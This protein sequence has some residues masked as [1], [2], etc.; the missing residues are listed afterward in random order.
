MN[1]LVVNCGS[2]TIKY[3]LFSMEEEDSYQVLAKG[4]VERIGTPGSC[5]EHKNDNH[6][7]V[8][9]REVSNHRVAM[10]WVMEV[11]KSSPV[12]C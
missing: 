3:Q 4:I 12:Q 8:E 9:E 6:S 5:L 2:S 10:Q 1:I 11:L 7:F